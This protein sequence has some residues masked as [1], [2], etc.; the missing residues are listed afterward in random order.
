[1]DR[2]L[3]PLDGTD[4]AASILPDALRLVGETG[5]LLLV[6]DASHP[7]H[8]TSMGIYGQ[9]PAIEASELYL[10]GIA[11]ILRKH[12]GVVRTRTF[13]MGNAARSVEEAVAVFKPDIIACATH[14]RSGVQRLLYG[15]MAHRILTH[16][17]VPVMLRH[18]TDDEP[19]VEFQIDRT[20]PR[21]IL[22]PLDGSPLAETALPLAR[23]LSAE[24]DADLF[25]VRV[26]TRDTAIGPLGV[27]VPQRAGSAD[28]VAD[29]EEAEDYLNGVAAGIAGP[30]YR[31]AV[32]GSPA[33][34]LVEFVRAQEI[35]DVVMA[36]HGR[37]GL[38]RIL[39]GS[40]AD[41]LIHRLHRPI[42]VVPAL[43]QVPVDLAQEQT[44][45]HGRLQPV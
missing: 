22:V 38:A 29:I 25:L 37:T 44:V 31:T 16:S 18:A 1:M 15:S 17:T 33:D 5:E 9:R 28:D 2:V 39:L 40:V 20:A 26:V 43:A 27:N 21:R 45:Q 13:A 12:G 11:H 24:W 42:V 7:A 35:T 8:D 14:G 10:G 30:V 41:E 3:V 4:L 32:G 36:S 23:R 34:T 19:P 6:R